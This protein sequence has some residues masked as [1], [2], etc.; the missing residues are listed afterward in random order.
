[1]IQPLGPILYFLTVVGKQ[2]MNGREG[3]AYDDPQKK[4]EDRHNIHGYAIALNEE[5]RKVD[6]KQDRGR[7]MR[8]EVDCLV[9]QSY[10]ASNGPIGGIRG[11]SVTR[12]D[13]FVVLL[14]FW[15]VLPPR[16]HDGAMMGD[17]KH[18]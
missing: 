17:G 18:N 2:V 16:R 4:D 9:M 1:M 10:D 7:Q 14:P 6:K 5:L 11:L 15:Q 8:P 13:I 12:T 3:K